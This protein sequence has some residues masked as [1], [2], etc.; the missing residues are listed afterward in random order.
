MV[1]ENPVPIS[2][3]LQKSYRDTMQT[4]TAPAFLDPT[5]PIQPVAVIANT[6]TA[7]SSVQVT[8]GTDTL[9][10]NTDGSL[11]VKRTASTKHYGT[12]KSA[13]SITAGT[14]TTIGTVTASVDFYCT[15]MTLCFNRTMA[16]WVVKDG[17]SGGTTMLSG[18]GDN[19][20]NPI[21]NL[22]FPNP[23]KFGTDIWMD[24]EAN[25]G[26]YCSFVGYEE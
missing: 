3:T 26:V 14:G 16:G 22:S 21:I 19:A 1:L 18:G 5:L 8:D 6:S 10:V 15:A 17:G 12:G 11:N 23:L 7:A 9:L 25:A 13:V 4:P 2:T 24:V 20:S